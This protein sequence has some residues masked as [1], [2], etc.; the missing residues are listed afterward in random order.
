MPLDPGLRLGPYEIIEPLGAGGMGEVYRAKDTRLDR[1][2][3]VKILP[4]HLSLNPE[5]RQRFDREARAISSLTH[6]HICALYDVGHEDGTD[7]L[8]ME[9]L[10]GQTLADRLLTGPLPLED[11]LR[12]GRQIAEALAAA[13]RSGVV[14]RDLKPGNVMLTRS[15]VK[16]LD[17]GL[18]KTGAEAATPASSLTMKADSGHPHTP[19]T[20]EGTI[21]GT[22]QYMAPEQLEGAESDARTDIF[23]LG[24]VLY[25]M[26]TGR[27]AFEGKSQASLIA[28]IMSASPAP[29]SQVV[30]LT[31]P[32]LDRVVRTCLKKDPE[33]RWQTAHDVALQLEW[34]AEGGSA[35][36]I[37]KPVAHRRRRRE[38]IAWGL[39]AVLGA[40]LVVS[41]GWYALNRPAE[42]ARHMLRYQVPVP[43]GVSAVDSPKLSPDGR[44]MAFNAT[45]T[46]GKAMLWVQP[47]NSL[48]A[49]PLPGTEGARRAIW[50][51]DSRSVAFFS[52]GRL[53]RV[54]IAGGPAQI[55]CEAASGAD[56]AWSP[57][58]VIIFDGNASDSLRRVPDTGGI[59]EAASV[60]NHAEHEQA[61]AWPYFLPDGKHFLFQVQY[62]DNQPNVIRVGELGS[63]E[64]RTLERTDSRMEYARP[65]YI[66]WVQDRTLLARKFDPGSRKFTGEP[67]PVLE[68]I[69]GGT[70]G[71]AQF[72][73]SSDGLLAYREQ[74]R[75]NDE[76]VMLDRTGHAS[77]LP[78]GAAQFG[79]P[80]FSPDGHRVAVQITDPGSGTA[81]LWVLDLDRTTR[82]R[83]T[84]VP[85]DDGCGIWSPDGRRLAF[86]SDRDGQY[87]I[88][89]KPADGTGNAT[90]VFK[91][92]NYKEPCSWS[93][94]GKYILFHTLDPKTRWDVLAVP[95]A[96]G[97]TMMV[98]G[99]EFTQGKPAVS[100]DGRWV[101]YQSHETRQ[102][103]VYVQAFPK[104]SGKWQVSIDGGTEPFWTENG[105]EICF[106]SHD[107][108]LMTVDVSAEDGGGL[109]TGTPV[110]RFR[111]PVSSDTA[112]RNR[113]CP[114]AAGDRFLAV[115]PSNAAGLPPTMIMVD[116]VSELTRRR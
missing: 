86:C 57:E 58:G 54:D 63:F 114:D 71:L 42:P 8:V 21:L 7:F 13:H 38:R 107:R 64:T 108:D 103:Q 40:A 37:P 51:P 100:P 111:I 98:A 27:R 95:A 52:D 106:L 72:S 50:S 1:S 2:V 30:P 65:G 39:V 66:L 33:E 90:L 73:T 25:E 9:Y 53:R 46:T 35:A 91:S 116:W 68:S 93:P 20:A 85:A 87:D 96:G 31:P 28:S 75:S 3:A 112:T 45:D 48:T 19:L 56:G 101:A 10:E 84:L 11:V 15:G 80:A 23:A 89:V 67:F 74:A 88:Y 26:L 94:D 5:L 12:I 22:F 29:I 83:L 76:L 69:G 34:I 110:R 61:H 55:L 49:H 18:A 16:L 70:L 4:G 81:D 113:W 92:A 43:D 104:P 115:S 62:S 77:V 41:A 24:A 59:P 14:H 47:L 99:G 82:T 102:M 97:D 60:L 32:A 17:F 105:R 44:Y 6:P 36:G 109:R 79:D 78:F